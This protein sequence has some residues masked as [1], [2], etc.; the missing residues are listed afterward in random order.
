MK[1]KTSQIFSQRDSRWSSFI[2]GYNAPNTTFTIGN[3][4]CLITSLGMYVGKN[5][6][7]MNDILKENKGFSEKSGNF[8]WGKCTVLGLNQIYQSP[9]YSGEVT[10]QGLTKMRSLLDEGKPLLTHIDFDPRDPDDDQHW[11]LVYGYDN[12]DIFYTLDP[13]TGTAITLDVYGGVKRAVL[14]FRAYDKVLPKDDEKD[15]QAQID[16][17]RKE[18]DTNWGYFSGLCDVMKIAAVFE[19][20]KSELEKLVG[21]EDKYNQA[22]GQLSEA[23][24]QINDLKGQLNTLTTSHNTLQSSYNDLQGH[25]N[26]DKDTID[27]LTKQ[28]TELEKAVLAPVRKGWKAFLV[29]LVDRI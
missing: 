2:L 24:T 14:E 19:T 6:Q 25:L 5:P 3:F 26:E 8:I 20:A 1:L 12:N 23:Q 13:W 29:A 27:T 22:S 11:V 15:F 10:S 17:L 21:I 28:L 9:Y 7:E 4:G 16:Q 18:R